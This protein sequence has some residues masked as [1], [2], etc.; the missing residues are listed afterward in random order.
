[1]DLRRRAPDFILPEALVVESLKN[2]RQVSVLRVQDPP[3]LE[4]GPKI[5]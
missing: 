1:M 2:Q 5:P 3:W 4:K